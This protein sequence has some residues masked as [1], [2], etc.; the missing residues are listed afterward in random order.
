MQ[1]AIGIRCINR[2]EVIDT[3]GGSHQNRKKRDG[4][5]V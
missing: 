3:A 4:D 1:G 2:R 5:I